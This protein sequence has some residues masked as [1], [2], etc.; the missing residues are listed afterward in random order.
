MESMQPPLLR[1]RRWALGIFALLVLLVLL[2]LAV[3]SS[4]PTIV[5]DLARPHGPPVQL[6]GARGPL[7]AAQSKAILERLQAR[8]GTPTSSTATWR[9]RRPSSA[10][11]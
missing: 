8:P 11:R 10:V 3:R 1:R 9:A 2:G 6:E 4:L 5:P 7:S